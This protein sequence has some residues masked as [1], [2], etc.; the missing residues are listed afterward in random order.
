MNDYEK[1]TQFNIKINRETVFRL[2]DCYP[3]SHI[4]SDVL[5]EYIKMENEV[6]QLIQPVVYIKF[7]ILPDE[8]ATNVVIGGTLVIYVLMTLGNKV[9]EL[10]E[11]HGGY[12]LV[13]A[14]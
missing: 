7:G 5:E 3:E 8:L 11:C 14:G 1:I 2:I 9:T 10:G 12:L 6:C 4:Y 13:S